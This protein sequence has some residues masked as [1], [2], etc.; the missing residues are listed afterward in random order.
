[1]Y[2]L[3]IIEESIDDNRILEKAKQFFISQRIEEVPEDTCP[4]WHTN[5]YHVPDDDLED[6]LP[7]L[8]QHIKSTWYIHALMMII[9]M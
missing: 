6:L 3:G 9:F 8:E 5:E 7:V 4:I 1:M 2:R